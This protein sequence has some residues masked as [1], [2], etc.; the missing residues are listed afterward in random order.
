MSQKVELH[1]T[2]PRKQESYSDR[3]AATRRDNAL[4][5]ALSTPPKPKQEQVKPKEAKAKAR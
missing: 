5:R 1:K 2:E 3:D 4:R